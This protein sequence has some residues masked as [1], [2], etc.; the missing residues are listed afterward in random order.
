MKGFR[1]RNVTDL[2]V[3]EMYRDASVADQMTFAGWP[4]ESQAIARRAVALEIDSKIEKSMADTALGE[5]IEALKIMF[6]E[7]KASL[8]DAMKDGPD[9]DI[10]RAKAMAAVT[11]VDA[12]IQRIEEAAETEA[13][14]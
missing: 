8:A 3:E 1:V 12:A 6:G 11:E 10:G 7:L 9:G 14:E 5:G 13:D 4:E 2:V